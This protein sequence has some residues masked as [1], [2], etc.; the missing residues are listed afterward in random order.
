M[1]KL[2]KPITIT[3]I[4]PVKGGAY[5]TDHKGTMHFLNFSEKVVVPK[6]LPTHYRDHMAEY[7]T[8]EGKKCDQCTKDVKCCKHEPQA[9]H[10]KFEELISL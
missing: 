4:T 3:A 2:I 7:I 9:K 6:E 1:H 5:V 8:S 10:D